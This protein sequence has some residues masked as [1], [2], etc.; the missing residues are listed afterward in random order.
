MGRQ[1]TILQ[2]VT[3]NTMTNEQCTSATTKYP[4]ASIT[5]NMICAG[6][7]EN[8][9]CQGDSGGPL[10]AR[11]SGGYYSQIGVVSYGDKCADARAPGVYARVTKQ[12]DWIKGDLCPRPEQGSSV[13]RCHGQENGCC[14]VETPCSEGEGDCDSND[15]CRGSLVCG[16]NNCPKEGF[17]WNFGDD[18]CFSWED[19]PG[20]E[21]CGRDRSCEEKHGDCDGDEEC[22]GDLVCGGTCSW[23]SVNPFKKDD[24]CVKK[25]AKK[26]WNFFNLFGV[27]ED[28]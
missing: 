10:I 16:E 25:T 2:E 20:P 15:H 19:K 17:K 6:Y 24:C 3:V 22:K 27:N 4:K 26:T 13:L 21:L 1:A 18:C 23:A 7:S 28:E 9:S 8:D 11:E 5:S 14:T 12:L